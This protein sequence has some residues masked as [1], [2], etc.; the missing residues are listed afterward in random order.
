MAPPAPSVQTPKRSV[1]FGPTTDDERGGRPSSVAMT[2]QSSADVLAGSTS[3]QSTPATALK[4]ALK[5]G[6]KRNKLPSKEQYQHSDPLLRRLR[7]VDAAGDPVDLR[8]YFRHV[9]C[10]GFYFSSQWAGQPLKEYH[11]VRARAFSFSLLSTLTR[12]HH[13]T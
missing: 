13:L 7:L 1:S 3:A 11:Q 5:A 6:S 9:K 4:P 8:T 10:V 2:P 12:V